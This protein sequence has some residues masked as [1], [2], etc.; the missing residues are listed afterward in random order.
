M[1][2]YDSR[3]IETDAFLMAC[4]EDTSVLAGHLE[5]FLLGE[6]LAMRSGC[7]TLASACTAEVARR[8]CSGEAA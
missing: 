8:N 5:Q 4:E 3:Y 2:E 7:S 1:S 6:L